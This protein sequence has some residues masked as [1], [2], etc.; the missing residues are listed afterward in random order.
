[1]IPETVSQE[2]NSGWRLRSFQSSGDPRCVVPDPVR[3]GVPEEIEVL[4]HAQLRDDRKRPLVE[5]GVLGPLLEGL[6][7]RALRQQRLQ[8]LAFVVRI[9]DDFGV[10]VLVGV[11][12]LQF[13]RRG[14]I[15][16]QARWGRVRRRGA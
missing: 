11:R 10:L 2:V 6:L 1:L 9:A 16:V 8:F 12:L 7:P 3:E 13:G 4:D 5:V 14:A 15:D